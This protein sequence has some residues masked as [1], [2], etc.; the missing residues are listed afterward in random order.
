[1]STR[2]RQ[3]RNAEPAI[4]PPP[5]RSDPHVTLLSGQG[6]SALG[7]AKD[8]LD[9]RQNI[10]NIDDAT[11]FVK[12]KWNL[13][14]GRARW[15]VPATSMA[16]VGGDKLTLDLRRNLAR[17]HAQHIA[18]WCYLPWNIVKRGG[19]RGRRSVLRWSGRHGSCVPSVS[20]SC[21][22]AGAPP[23]LRIEGNC[24][25][26]GTMFDNLTAACFRRIPHLYIVPASQCG[27]REPHNNQSR[28]HMLCRQSPS[29]AARSQAPGCS[30]ARRILA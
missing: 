5:R 17:S 30:R 29:S 22:D 11:L 7:A 10:V 21:V 8:A 18:L 20:R 23:L 9:M 2:S 25:R 26:P 3:W 27:R 1:M 24:P 15:D 14:F 12:G 28:N 6:P 19:C 16:A 13:Q 4:R